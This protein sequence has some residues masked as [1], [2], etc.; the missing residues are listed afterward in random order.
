MTESGMRIAEQHAIREKT[1]A[2][3]LDWAENRK[4][5]FTGETEDGFAEAITVAHLVADEA[6]LNLHRWIDAARR[7]GL[8]WTDL[9]SALGISK[10]AAQQRF[11]SIDANDD[12]SIAHEEEIVRTR[13]SAIF[14]ERKILREEGLKR[15]ELIR[16]NNN[17]LVFRPTGHIWEYRRRV[18]FS[19]MRK[20]MRDAGWTLVSTWPPVSYFKRQVPME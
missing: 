2:L 14:N 4:P 13:Y 7:T 1:S 6:K 10:Q 12:S 20:E 19:A 9:G 15:N 11:K 3:V 17:S 16:T 18:G 8:S 5:P